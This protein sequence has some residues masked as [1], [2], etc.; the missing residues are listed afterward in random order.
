MQGVEMLKKHAVEFNT[1]SVVNRKTSQ[2]PLAVYNFLKQIGSTFLQFIPI[3]E[4]K[5]REA[6]PG[7]QE[8]VHQLYEGDASVTEW[9]VKPKYY[10]NF[11]IKIFE[12]WV[13]KDVGRTYVQLFDVTL[14]NWVGAMPGLCIFSETCGTAAVMEHNGDVFTCDH[15]VYED[16]LLGNIKETPITQ[17]MG[18]TKQALFGQDKKNKLPAYC[19]SR[20]VRFACHGDCP[21]HRF[22]KTPQGDP[23]LNYLCEGYKMFF[24]HVKPY[25]DFMTKELKAVRAPANVMEWLR[26]KE[27]AQAPRQTKIGRNTPAPAGVEK[28]ISSAMEGGKYKMSRSLKVPV[29]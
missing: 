9:S 6:A 24:E 25:M 29:Y 12:E 21:K 17:M 2:E 16:H 18:S 7:D 20:P 5:A 15:Y 11:M 22:I 4:R 1:L 26:R 8:L 19:R 14:A 28:S 10:G 23:G 27:Q 3:V 13:R